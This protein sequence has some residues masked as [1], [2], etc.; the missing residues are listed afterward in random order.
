MKSKLWKSMV[1]AGFAAALVAGT[2]RAQ[3]TPAQGYEPIDDTPS[4][5]VGGTIFAD[6]TYQDAPKGTDADG[7]SIHPNSFNVSRAY[8]NVFGNLSH[9]ISARVTS[10]VVRESDGSGTSTSINGSYVYRLK[11]AYGQVNL[12]EWMGKGTWLRL[13][14]NQTPYIDSVESVYRY[15][16]QGAIF[17]D[18]EGFLT[19]SDLGLSAHYNFPANYGDI[20]LGVYNG[21]GYSKPE[22]N[23]QKAFQIRASLRPAPAVPVLKGLRLTGFYDADHYQQSDKKTR[24]VGAL[25]FEHPYVNFG[26][27]WL[28]AKDKATAAGSEVHAEGYSLWATPR[29]PIGIEAL[30]RYDNLKPNKDGDAHK[31]RTIAGIAYWFPVQKG[32]SAAL[33]ADYETVKYSNYSPSRTTEKRWALHTLFSF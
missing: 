11:Y 7:N 31:K 32:V 2:A 21:E 27:E 19:S 26:A 25:T 18:R 17:V 29:T 22:A 13:G 3:V 1:F 8:I 16:F 23:N 5:K 10:D 6:Y 14:L 15:R 9:L 20:H 12:D 33:L 28:D 4:V 30:L 24:F